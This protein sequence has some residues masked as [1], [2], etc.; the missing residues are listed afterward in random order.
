MRCYK[1]L[2]IAINSICTVF[3]ACVAW[4]FRPHWQGDT[5]VIH[6]EGV[7][8]FALV[9]IGARLFVEILGFPTHVE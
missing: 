2:A 1:V 8:A 9:V 6:I 5:F 7:M 4:I 3:M